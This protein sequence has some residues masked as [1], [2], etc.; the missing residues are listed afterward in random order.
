MKNNPVKI[1]IS[2]LYTHIYMKK[3]YNDSVDL[4]TDE[5]FVSYHNGN[6]KRAEIHF[7]TT[8]IAENPDKL[9]LVTEART[10]LDALNVHISEGELQ[11][12]KDKLF[13]KLE[14]KAPVKT[15]R[16]GGKWR[17]IAALLSCSSVHFHFIRFFLKA[18]LNLRSPYILPLL[19]N[20]FM[21]PPKMA[22]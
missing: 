1:W 2:L 15:H 22:E 20:G 7:W 12:E 11:V 17:W 6:A 19:K 18:R 14:S 9:H 3:I 4:V 21:S 10:M 13:A 5:S 16:L 8:W